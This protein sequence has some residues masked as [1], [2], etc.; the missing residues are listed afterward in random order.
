MIKIIVAVGNYIPEKGFPIGKDGGMAWHY[1][2]D[3]KWFKKTTEGNTVVMGRNTYD[4]IGGKPLANRSNY[5]VSRTMTDIPEGFDGILGCVDDIH[6]LASNT[7]G[8]VYI[9]GG[10][11]LYRSALEADIVDEVLIDNIPEDVPDADTFFQP[12][13]L[14]AWVVDGGPIT[15]P[16]NPDTGEICFITKFKHAGFLNDVDDKYLNLVQEILMD[17]EVKE[18]RAGTT[19]SLFGRQLRFDLKKGLPI[20]T[21]KKVYTNGIIRPESRSGNAR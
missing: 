18:T 21:T 3:L 11:E 10:A 6:G 19:R 16:E 15:L 9:I 4:A 1:P 13:D 17:G 14:D 20:L 5:I 12:L 2:E 7:I 8:D